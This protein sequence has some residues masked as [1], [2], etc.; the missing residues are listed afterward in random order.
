MPLVPES[1]R[2]RQDV[3]ASIS[4]QFWEQPVHSTQSL[5]GQLWSLPCEP[6]ALNLTGSS[7]LSRTQQLLAAQAARVPF[8]P[9]YDGSSDGLVSALGG[10]GAWLPALPRAALHA[11]SRW[12]RHPPAC[13][14]TWSWNHPPPFLFPPLKPPHT[15]CWTGCWP[16]PGA[17][18]GGPL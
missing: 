14:P 4:S 12:V 10:G 13:L 3:K 6:P 18:A 17:R 7:G 1:R 5:D 16:R 2:S 11:G 8:F 9:S 15:R